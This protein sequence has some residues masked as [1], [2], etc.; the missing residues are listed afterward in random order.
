MLA[1]S[2]K[3]SSKSLKVSDSFDHVSFNSRFIFDIDLPS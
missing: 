3:A 1:L 2:R